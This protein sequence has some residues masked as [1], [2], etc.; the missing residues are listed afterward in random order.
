MSVLKNRKEHE[1]ITSSEFDEE[2]EEGE[3]DLQVFKN[4]WCQ[5]Y[6]VEQMLSFDVLTS[7]VSH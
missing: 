5:K 7:I 2:E 4:T 1:I 6:Y 3:I